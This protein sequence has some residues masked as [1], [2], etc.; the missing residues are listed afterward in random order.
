MLYD[1]TDGS[2][3]P[4]VYGPGAGTLCWEHSCASGSSAVGAW[5]ACEAG[6]SLNL[7]LRQSGGQ[8]GISAVVEDGALCTLRL[9]GRVSL[10]DSEI[11]KI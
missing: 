4:L 1:E 6:E 7:R 8:L 9:S 3:A 5:L 10:G 11:I 2:L